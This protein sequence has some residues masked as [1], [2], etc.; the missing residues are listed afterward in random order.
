MMSWGMPSSLFTPLT[1]RGVTLR[2]RD[3]RLAD[4]R[5][6]EPRRLRRTT[7]TWSTSA[8]ARSA[9]PALVLTEATAVT[10]DGRISAGR[11]RHLVATRTSSRWRAIVRFIEEHGAVP[12]IQ[13]AHAG[14]KASTSAPWTGR[15]AGRARQT[16]AGQPIWAP[17]AIPFRD[18]WQV[19]RALTRRRHHAGRRAPSPRRRGALLDAGCE[20]VGDPRGARLPAAR[21]PLAAEQ[22][23]RRR[24]RRVVREPHPHRPR[25]GG[26]DPRRVA[27]AAIRCSC[28]SPPPTG[29]TAAGRS[30]TRS[31]WP[32]SSRRAASIW[33]TARPAA[34]WPQ[35]TIP[36]GPGYQVPFAEQRP[37]RGRHPDR[38]GRPDHRAGAGR[39]DRRDPARPMW[40]CWRARCCA[41]RT[42]RSTPPR[43]SA[44]PLPCRRNTSALTDR[45]SGSEFAGSRFG[46]ILGWSRNSLIE[47][48]AAVA[49]ERSER[50]TRTERAGEAARER[51][52][53]GVRGAKPLG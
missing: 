25:S 9:A 42:G 48:F 19:P 46:R 44:I 43:R 35:A 10:A 27:G 50:A 8:A 28:G 22:S 33:S 15:R 34:T 53:R 3:R 38:R 32:R 47:S 16:A 17:S 11:S 12:G 49:S 6:L 13:L 7:G 31:S 18:G 37:A 14:R 39:R 24:V 23:A 52:C 41:I 36:V 4:V 26:R 30:T 20:I 40:C 45:G 21:V 2:N 5:V 51:A 1:L 29:P